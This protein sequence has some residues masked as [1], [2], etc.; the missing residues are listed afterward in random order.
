[1]TLPV[2]AGTRPSSNCAWTPSPIKASSPP[3]PARQSPSPCATTSRSRSPD[4]AA[5]L[6]LPAGAEEQA[7]R[8]SLEAVHNAVKHADATAIR[9]AVTDLDDAVAVTNSNNGRGFD[10]T[11]P[12]PGHLGLTTMRERTAQIGADLQLTTTPGSGTTVRLTLPARL[13]G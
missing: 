12:R 1:V 13:G 7:Y 6:R 8:S 3:S 9:V 5:R 10:P 11:T 2:E 4:P